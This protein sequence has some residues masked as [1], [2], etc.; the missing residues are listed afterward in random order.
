MGKI[1]KKLNVLL[2][3][4]QKWTMVWLLILMLIGA[5]LEVASIGI[6]VPVVSIVM[7]ENAINDGGI[8]QT[9]YEA[10]PVN[11]VR[12]F[13]IVIMLSLIV[14]FIVKNIFLFIQQKFMLAFV[15]GNQFSTSERLMKNY[16][17][18]SYEYYLNADTAVVQRNITS[19]VNNMYA[20][21]LALLQLLSEGIVFACLVAVLFWQ[22]PVMTVLVTVVLLIVLFIIKV[23]LKPIMHKAGEDNQNFY[24]GLYKLISQTVM[25][26]KEVKVTGKEQ[27]FVDEYVVCGKGYVNAVQKYSLYNNIP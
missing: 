22:D 16:L 12:Q 24:S 17:R 6:V 20:L 8:V 23:V 3:K 1:L 9:L 13:T 15:Y 25:G 2:D 18:K 10:L 21:I 26:I 4:K 5:V 14:A 19:D 7:D 27:Y 11:S